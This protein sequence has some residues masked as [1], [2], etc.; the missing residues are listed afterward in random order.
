MEEFK[1][2]SFTSFVIFSNLV[3]M[4]TFNGGKVNHPIDEEATCWGLN[5][6]QKLGDLLNRKS[7]ERKKG[8]NIQWL[9]R[10]KTDLTKELQRREKDPTSNCGEEVSSE[11]YRENVRKWRIIEK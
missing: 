5:G 7:V 1:G 11:T 6:Q 9:D 3:T 8:G 10:K 2:T 4:V